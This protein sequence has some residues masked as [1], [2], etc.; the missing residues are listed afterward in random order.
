[1]PAG[2]VGYRA[3]LRR[4]NAEVLRQKP[5]RADLRDLSLKSLS[6]RGKYFNISG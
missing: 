2:S 3:N 5:V 4:R 6:G 1:L